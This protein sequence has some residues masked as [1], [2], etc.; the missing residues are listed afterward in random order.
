MK[1]FCN[2]A[3]RYY[4]ARKETLPHISILLEFLKAETKINV[5]QV[6]E[7]I[8]KFLLFGDVIHLYS[9]KHS[10]IQNKAKQQQ[11]MSQKVP[12]MVLLHINKNGCVHLLSSIK[13]NF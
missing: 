9:N 2:R 12:A 8:P 5:T 7:K 4:L 3:T 11:E 1:H 13:K 6:K 10:V